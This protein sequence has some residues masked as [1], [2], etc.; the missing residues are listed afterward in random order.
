LSVVSF[1]E[2]LHDLC[3]AYGLAAVYLFGTQARPPHG[4][5]AD[6]Q[7]GLVFR[8]PLPAETAVKLHPKLLDTFRE[9]FGADGLSVVFLQQAG[10]LL[11]YQGILGRLLYSADGARRAEFEEKVL[12]DYLDFA[13]E[14]RL[15]DEE[16][17]EEIEHENGEY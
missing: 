1:A 13:F 12:R 8:K 2:G 10:P 14:A 9:L 17:A 5:P 15:F 4:A 16:F 7:V 6:A 11:Q 3:Q